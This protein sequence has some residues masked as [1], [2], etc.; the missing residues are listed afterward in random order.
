MFSRRQ[1]LLLPPISWICYRLLPICSILAAYGRAHRAPTE[2]VQRL[3]LNWLVPLPVLPAR[4]QVPERQASELSLA[5]KCQLRSL[6][7]RA[8]TAVHGAPLQLCPPAPFGGSYHLP[9]SGQGAADNL[10]GPYYIRTATQAPSLVHHG[11]AT[12]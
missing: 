4:S 12:L 6:H 8:A 9:L 5:L 11:L 3:Q 1:K 7:A 10:P 2:C